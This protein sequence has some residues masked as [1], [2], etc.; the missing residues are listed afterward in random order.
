MLVLVLEF[1]Y[2]AERKLVVL[3]RGE[4]WSKSVP[5][6]RDLLAFPLSPPI[7]YCFPVFSQYQIFVSYFAFFFIVSFATNLRH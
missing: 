4:G 7:G 3:P 5:F 2:V 1:A 6:G